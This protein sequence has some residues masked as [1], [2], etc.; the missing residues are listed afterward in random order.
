MDQL[1][2]SVSCQIFSLNPF[3]TGVTLCWHPYTSLLAGVN[4]VWHPFV[5]LSGRVRHSILTHPYCSWTG[6]PTVWHYDA[7]TYRCHLFMCHFYVTRI[8]N[9][10]NVTCH[11]WPGVTIS[12]HH[13][14]HALITET[15]ATWHTDVFSTRPGGTLLHLE[16]RPQRVKDAFQVGGRVL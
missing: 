11:A 9:A 2:L 12:G 13:M 6:D 8:C 4:I 5:Y 14:C 10:H 15:P 16:P 7:V 1:I 3:R